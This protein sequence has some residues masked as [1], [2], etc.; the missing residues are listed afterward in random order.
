MYSIIY[1]IFNLSTSKLHLYISTSSPLLLAPTPWHYGR[2]SLGTSYLRPHGRGGYSGYDVGGPICAPS[3]WKWY[4]SNRGVYTFCTFVI[5]ERTILWLIGK[6][7]QFFS[8]VTLAV[9]DIVRE[10]W[11]E[12]NA[13]W[14]IL[15]SPFLPSKSRLAVLVAVYCIHCCFSYKVSCPLRT[16]KYVIFDQD[17][18]SSF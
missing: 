7:T 4:Y 1:P 5:T 2:L 13:S 16:H 17:S 18:G 11:I 12:V 14:C 6:T 9:G 10:A 8:E 3:R 15:F